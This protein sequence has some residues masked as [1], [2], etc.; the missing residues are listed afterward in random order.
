[1]IIT[2]VEIVDSYLTQWVNQGLCVCFFFFFF[3]GGGGGDPYNNYPGNG[4][5]NDTMQTYGQAENIRGDRRSGG[6]V[7]SI[8]GAVFITENVR[9]HYLAS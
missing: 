7:K 9:Y 6:Y 8:R 5:H 4:G 3:L 2:H 1:M